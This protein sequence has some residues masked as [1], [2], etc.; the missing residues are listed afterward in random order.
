M[1]VIKNFSRPPTDGSVSLT[2]DTGHSHEIIVKQRSDRYIIL[3]QSHLL[4]GGKSKIL[5]HVHRD[6]TVWFI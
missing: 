2:F 1:I 5:L 4:V 3:V 6:T